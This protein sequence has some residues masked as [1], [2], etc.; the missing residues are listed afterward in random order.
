MA[1][2]LGRCARRHVQLVEFDSRAVTLPAAVCKWVPVSHV[3]D[4][5]CGLPLIE[6][7][8]GASAKGDAR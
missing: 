8:L 3:G 4:P 7:A 2:T 5:P 6:W 1:M